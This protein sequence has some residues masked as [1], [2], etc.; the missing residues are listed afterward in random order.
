MYKTR[1][2]PVVTLCPEYSPRAWTKVGI[3][4]EGEGSSQGTLGRVTC[5][6]GQ[7]E[8][9]LIAQEVESRYI[10]AYRTDTYSITVVGMRQLF[11]GA[12]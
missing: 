1:G 10:Q 7:V 5:S 3:Q 12:T 11:R 6:D 8:L 2:D 9:Y 4:G